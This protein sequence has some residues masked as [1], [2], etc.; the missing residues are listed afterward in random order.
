MRSRRSS[1]CSSAKIVTTR[2]MPALASGERSGEITASP[3][4]NAEGAG[5]VTTTGRGCRSTA[6]PGFGDARVADSTRL[7]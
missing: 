2:M 4:F 7:S 6:A 1:C 3:I 5:W